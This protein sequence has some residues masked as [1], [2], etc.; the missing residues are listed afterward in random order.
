MNESGRPR[1]STASARLVVQ[2]NQLLW[3]TQ[4]S[5]ASQRVSFGE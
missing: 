3:W 2:Q 1:H 4:G 5:L